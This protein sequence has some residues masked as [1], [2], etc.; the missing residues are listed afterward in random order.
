MTLLEKI[1]YIADLISA[2]RHFP[3]VESLR[4]KAYRCLDEAVFDALVL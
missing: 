2:D 4:E 3:G 1:L